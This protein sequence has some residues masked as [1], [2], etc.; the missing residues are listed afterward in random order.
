MMP[1]GGASGSPTM[2]LPCGEP[3]TA[4]PDLSTVL[5]DYRVGLDTELGILTALE[6]IAVR[7]RN[8]PQPPT[9]E[10]LTA[11]AE[12]RGRQLTALDALEARLAPLRARLEARLDETRALPG[13]DG[14][15]SRRQQVLALVQRITALD[16]ESLNALQRANQDRRAAAQSI[17]TGGATLAAYRRVVQHVPTAGLLDRKL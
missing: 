10:A 9:A 5:A 2:P 15:L 13:F 16:T 11:L 14:V 4:P 12:E 1:R 3:M 17:E 8:L 6:A 7:Q